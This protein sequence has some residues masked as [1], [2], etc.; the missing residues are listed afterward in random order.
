MCRLTLVS[1]MKKRLR[2]AGV[3]AKTLRGGKGWGG[4][5]ASGVCDGVCGVC[6]SACLR[7]AAEIGLM[8]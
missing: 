6:L 1:G 2:S 7:L 8:P 5:V 3:R 4:W